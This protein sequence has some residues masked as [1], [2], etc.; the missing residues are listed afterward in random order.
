MSASQWLR[1]H[2]E[3]Y[4]MISAHERMARRYGTTAPRPPHGIQEIFWRRVFAPLYRLLPWSLRH[5]IMLAMPG[6]HRRR[7]APPPTPQGSALD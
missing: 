7:W 5:K 1:T 2:S 4:L 6:S 3:H